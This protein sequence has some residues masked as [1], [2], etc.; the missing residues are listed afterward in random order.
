MSRYSTA[1]IIK[2]E[3][4]IRHSTTTIIPVVPNSVND[5]YINITSPHR[6]DKLAYEFYGNSSLWWIIAVTNGLGKGTLYAKQ[7]TRIRIPSKDNIQD[8]ISTTNIER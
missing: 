4:N 7:G 8:L 5:I 6:L 3:N 1:K 2:D